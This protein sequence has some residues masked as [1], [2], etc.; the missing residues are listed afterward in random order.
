MIE[1]HVS[2]KQRLKNAKP[3]WMMAVATCNNIF[4]ECIVLTHNKPKHP[5]TFPQQQQQQQIH[6]IRTTTMDFT[7]CSFPGG[8]DD[9]DSSHH[10]ETIQDTMAED[11]QGS[12]SA[13]GMQKKTRRKA[14]ATATKLTHRERNTVYLQQQ[15]GQ[16]DSNQGCILEDSESDDQHP[17]AFP[18]Q[19]STP[20]EAQQHYHEQQSFDVEQVVPS[21]E[22]PLLLEAVL[23][24]AATVDEVAQSAQVRQKIIQEAPHATE[25]PKDK[26]RLLVLAL[27]MTIIIVVVVLAA[28][29]S[30]VFTSSKEYGG[31]SIPPSTGMDFLLQVL[32]PISGVETLTDPS[33][34]QYKAIQ[35][36]AK[37]EDANMTLDSSITDP[38]IV[39]NRYVLAV[40]YFSTQGPSWH[41]QLGF[42]GQSSVCKWK[43]VT[44]RDN[45]PA[46]IT[47]LS[48]APNGLDGTIPLEI[49]AFSPSLEVLELFTSDSHGL[50]ANNLKGTIPASWKGFSYLKRLGFDSNQLSGTI[51]HWIGQSPKLL[52]VFLSGNFLTGTIPSSVTQLPSIENLGIGDNLLTG[53][54]PE[55]PLRS[56]IKDIYLAVNMLE[57]SLPASVWQQRQLLSLNVW[58]SGSLTGNIPAS[59][60][61]MDAVQ[62]LILDDNALTGDI[63]TEIGTLS[64]LVSLWLSGNQLTST[65]PS[66]LGKLYQIAYL[67]LSRNH[68]T[69]TIP[70]ELGAIQV[71]PEEVYERPI[72][73]NFSGNQL[74]GTVPLEFA[75]QVG[76]AYLGIGNNS[77]TGTLDPL[78]CNGTTF[79]ETTNMV[80]LGVDC[81]E[82]ICSCCAECCSDEKDLCEIYADRLCNSMANYQ[83]SSD[84]EDVFGT[85]CTC[86]DSYN[87]SCADLFCD[88]CS[89]D[90]SVC[91][92]AF[93]YGTVI[94][95]VIFDE[96]GW[97]CTE[98][99]TSGPK[100]GVEIYYELYIGETDY[101]CLVMV[102][103]KA[104]QS[105]TFDICNGNQNGHRIDCSNIEPDA[106]Y[107]ECDTDLDGGQL[108][109]LF[110]LEFDEQECYTCF[111]RWL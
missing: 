53:T 5:S 93:D 67:D 12:D 35:W 86:V 106:I 61:H 56:N 25:V 23:V 28:V 70:S 9:S 18:I 34:P 14:R 29:L 72:Y 15:L 16:D 31:S 19:P 78:F 33:T 6:T 79:Q 91:V 49:E 98:Q 82:V 88:S 107:S 92:N 74:T 36:L 8:R 58:E 52:D 95:P 24:D 41:D 17:G 77:L 21:E 109:Q 108:L 45:N 85:V 63:P 46:I 30:T 110:Q 3:L 87:V 100:T 55:F 7:K 104:C 54:I 22:P 60:K 39:I 64:N 83:A 59:I 57:G 103:G 81:N 105:C 51:P 37:E 10:E 94:N 65:I 2:S 71:L 27:V 99:Y 62:Y 89:K 1:Q 26:K 90:G 73:F 11:Q 4:N 111:P 97:R 68:L 47:R 20:L 42:L 96:S 75:S 32:S 48:I 43:G 76:L 13:D 101:H 69:G 84:I 80:I 44:C 40:L 38:D 66:Q 102:D 50:V